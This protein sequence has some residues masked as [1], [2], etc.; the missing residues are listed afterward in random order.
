MVGRNSLEVVIGVR[1][2]VPQHF[3]LEQ[4]TVKDTA[5]TVNPIALG[6]ARIVT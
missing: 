3:Y 5:W 2:P 4:Y 6:L 1:V